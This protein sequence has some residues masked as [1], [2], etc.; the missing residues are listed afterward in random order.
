MEG[1]GCAVPF[2]EYF[3]IDNDLITFKTPTKQEI[4]ESLA[5]V[6]RIGFSES[7]DQPEDIV[8]GEELRVSCHD[9]IKCADISII[10]NIKDGRF[11][12]FEANAR[13]LMEKG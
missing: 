5:G 6:D 2:Q 8:P 4:I 3:D 9:A 11:H 1:D 7:D 10:F 12:G 13:G